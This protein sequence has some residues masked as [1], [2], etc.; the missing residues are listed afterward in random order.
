MNNTVTQGLPRW[1]W[2][3]L[4]LAVV[5][6]TLLLFA[7]DRRPEPGPALVYDVSKY[8]SVDPAQVRYRETA[9]LPLDLQEPTGL[10]VTW[11]GRMLVTGNSVLLVLTA[12]GEEL[13][14]RDFGRELQCIACAPDG[15][16]YLGTRDAVILLP[17]PDGAPEA[18]ESLGE[19]TWLTSLAANETHV[20]AA[21]SGNA[22]VLQYDRTGRLVRQLGGKGNVDGG[23]K[24]IVPSHYFDLA[25]DRMGSL[26]VVN[27]GKLG[28][29]NY[30][31]DGS[32]LS[33]W[34]QPGMDVNSF[35]GCCNPIHIAFLN[36]NVLA[37]AE[38]GI[39]R[40]KVLAAD[41]SFLGVVA[42]PE[43]INEG[44]TPS[45]E[46]YAPA[47]VRDLAVNGDNRI[48]VLHGPL[49]SILVFE[50]AAAPGKDA[51]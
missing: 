30:R 49:H 39:N 34:H 38:K 21:D 41:R 17:S 3:V 22:R 12:S 45:D 23:P 48:L 10:A 14:R 5:G 20:Y 15:A 25:F 7:T 47:P 31:E 50:E 8:E 36:G 24:F 51:E 42:P 26:W 28:L 4:A 9:R 16:V 18:W 44:W 27:P 43:Q 37:A 29:E 40:V 11:D 13:S 35:C 46:A 19:E 6:V 2:A 33:V 1:L 32:L